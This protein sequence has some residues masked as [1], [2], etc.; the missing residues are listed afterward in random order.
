[1]ALGLIELRSSNV[2]TCNVIR[3]NTKHHIIP[4]RITTLIDSFRETVFS[5]QVG[6]LKNYQV[7]LKIKPGV[8]PVAQKERRIPFALRQK[9][10]QEIRK[11]EAAGIVEDVTN[12][13]TPWIN[14]LVVVPKSGDD[15]RLCIDMRCANKAVERIRYPIPTIDDVMITIRGCKVFTKLDLNSAFHQQHDKQI[16]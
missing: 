4:N 14:P 3:E 8:T 12:E 5:G 13:A 7:H 15:I 10:N 9:V 11:L 16:S 6:K 1:M 2:N